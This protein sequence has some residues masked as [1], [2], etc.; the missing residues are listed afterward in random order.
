MIR[1]QDN[2]GGFTLIE[3]LIVIAILTV[4]F[5]L[6]IIAVNPV[7][8]FAQADNTQRRSDIN[9][10]LNAVYQ[11]AADNRGTVPGV[12]SSTSTPQQIGDSSGNC[13]ITCTPTGTSTVPTCVN[14]LPYLVS[15]Y[16][17]DIPKDPD[18]SASSTTHYA[19]VKS[20][21]N[22]RLTVYACDAELSETIKITR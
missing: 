21:T 19:I 4:L 22:N 10:L 9:A 16:L 11:Y 20:S 12:V 7:R 18:Q 5:A 17:V 6:V 2:I 13:A 3:L 1:K 15:T 8:Q 14:L